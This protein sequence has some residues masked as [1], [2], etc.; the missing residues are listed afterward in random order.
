MAC[1]L[2]EQA[3]TLVFKDNLSEPE[4][5]ARYHRGLL[6]DA[7]DF[8]E[9]EARWVICRLAELPGWEPPGFDVD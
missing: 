2:S 3:Q 1:V 5:L 6:D 9:S 8:N 4:V 7:S